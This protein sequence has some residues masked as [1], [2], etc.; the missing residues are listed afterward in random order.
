[1][2]RVKTG[3]SYAV[4][5]LCVALFTAGTAWAV[6]R[7]DGEPALTEFQKALAKFNATSPLSPDLVPQLAHVSSTSVRIHRANNVD[8]IMSESGPVTEVVRYYMPHHADLTTQR[9]F[10]FALKKG[11]KVVQISMVEFRKIEEGDERA[12]LLR[13]YFS[14][15]DDGGLKASLD[16]GATPTPMGEPEIFGA[17]THYLAAVKPDSADFEL[18]LTQDG[19]FERGTMPTQIDL[20]Q[21]SP[22]W[23]RFGA[24]F[25]SHLYRCASGDQKSAWVTELHL[26]NRDARW[27][28]VG[29]MGNKTYQTGDAGYGCAED[30][31]SCNFDYLLLRHGS[32]APRSDAEGLRHW[33]PASPGEG[34]PGYP[35]QSR[36][37]KTR[38]L[39]GLGFVFSG[40]QGG[41]TVDRRVCGYNVREMFFKYMEAHLD[42]FLSEVAARSTELS[43]VPIES[44]F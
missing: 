16:P 13:Y 3:L 21:S 12:P 8:E 20:G 1:M 11:Q 4:L 31:L 18:T 44:T 17:N 26:E 42:A 15:Q 23:T 32:P 14:A 41:L 38:V 27:Y 5:S 43:F 19:R 33:D 28:L 30:A 6:Y 10:L 37:Y 36:E 25:Q 9:A 34:D 2:K 24:L 29:K 22:Y 35:Y 39:P 7:P 40:L